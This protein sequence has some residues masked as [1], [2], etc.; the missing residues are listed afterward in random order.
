MIVNDGTV[1]PARPFDLKLDPDV[2]NST[3][4]G[5]RDTHKQ[6]RHE[7]LEISEPV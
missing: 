4:L 3:L 7:G 6:F 5:A 1:L 2:L